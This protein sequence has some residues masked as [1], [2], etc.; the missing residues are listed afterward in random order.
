MS[1]KSVTTTSH[2]QATPSRRELLAA[3]HGP[4][5]RAHGPAAAG[6][7][8]RV[9]LVY[10]NAYAIGMASLGFQIAY[11]VL[12]GIAGVAPERFFLDTA[13]QGSIETGTPLGDFD[14][15]AFSAAYEMDGPHVL[16]LLE[17]AGLPLEARHRR[18]EA[19]WPLVLHGGVLVS[20]NRLPLYPFIDV[21]AHG[22]AEGILPPVMERLRR[23]GV[24]AGS[25]LAALAGLPG[26]EL[27]AGARAAAGLPLTAGEE[28]LVDLLDRPL[29]ELASLALP[30]PAAP[31]RAVAALLADAPFTSRI[32]TPH[33]EFSNMALVDLARGCPH[34]CTFCWIGHNAPA[35]R[36]RSLTEILAGIERLQPHTDRFGLVA[37]AV[38]AHPDIDPL[39]EEL[40]ARGLRVS[41]SSLRVE[42]VSDTMLR[43]LAAGGQRTVT[44]APEAGSRRVRRLLGKRITDEQIF[45]V[46]E[47]IF[48][49]GAENLKLYFMTGIP[50]ETDEEALAIAAFTEKIRAIQ[51]RWARPRGR[52]G[53]LQINLGVFVPK[54][55]IPL[56][57]IEPVPL[58]RIKSR[59][60]KV[61]QALARIPNTHTA[62]SSPD[63]ARAQG[64]LSMGGVE[65]ARYALLVREQGYDWRA[66]NRV[67]RAVQ[68]ADFAWKGTGAP[69]VATAALHAHSSLP[70]VRVE[71]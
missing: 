22:E 28:P 9:G 7:L 24:D 36:T 31:P 49:L 3:E 38:G 34:H 10:P 46:T 21:F 14:V 15:I 48:G 69:R 60:R 32:L 66:A 30:A 4:P 29:A 40:M 56:N 55:G 71:G 53:T 27:T 20:V 44:I 2:A 67:W 50:S 33:N 37:S 57:H 6:R 61:V 23:P 70:S 65:A 42:E 26:I 11:Q 54:P 51:L 19:G 52:M 1:P 58:A 13:A 62:V 16:D 45:A 68:P 12:E 47:K 63:L 5:A 41:Y 17:L 35:Y 8:L 64:V 25:R 59:L 39:C 43:A 18:P